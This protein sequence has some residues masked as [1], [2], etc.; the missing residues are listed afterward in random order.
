[1]MEEVTKVFEIRKKFTTE[2]ITGKLIF[3]KVDGEWLFIYPNAEKFDEKQLETILSKLRE[4]N[5]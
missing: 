1:M 2:S 3:E 5:K 4:L